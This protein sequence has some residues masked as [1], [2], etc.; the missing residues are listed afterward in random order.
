M[1]GYEL[2]FLSNLTASYLFE[3]AKTLI[4]RTTHQGIYQDD[5]LL[6]FKGK[7]RVQEITDW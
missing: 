7:K 6:V 5:N 3:E 4:N 2:E 1:G